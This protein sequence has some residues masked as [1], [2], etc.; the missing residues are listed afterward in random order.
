MENAHRPGATLADLVA[1]MK[2]LLAPDGCPWDREQ[3]LD[4]LRSYLLEETYEVLEAIETGT[5]DEH[6]EELG[7]LLMQIV[8]QAEL[9]TAEG[10]FGIDDVVRSIHDKLVRR[11]PH[12]FGDASGAHEP[13][14]KA[15]ATITSDEVL[16]QWQQLKEK[17][18]PRRT[19]DGVPAALPALTRALRLSERA[20]QVGFDWPDVAG[21]RAKVAEECVE[22]DQ[23]IAPG[24]AARV[25][26]EIGDLL[27]AIVSLARK[28]GQDPEA[29][30]RAANARF[31]SRFEYIEDRLRERGRAPKQS[32]LEEMDALWDDAKRAQDARDTQS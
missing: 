25:E 4:T 20:A 16:A 2:R 24:H 1:V 11:H 10:K 17:E 12:V 14:A 9:R 21:C 15:R 23:A 13:D 22:V 32:T 3:T 28:L 27:Y 31:T 30:L 29:A 5:P 8:F 6:C 19:L 7:D 26:H 18:K